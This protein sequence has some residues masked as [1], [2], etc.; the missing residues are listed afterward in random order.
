MQPEDP[1]EIRDIV[2]PD[3]RRKT[4][5]TIGSGYRYY[6]EDHPILVPVITLL[7]GGLC[8][9]S[10]IFSNLAQRVFLGSRADDPTVVSGF[11]TG[12]SWMV[13]FAFGIMALAAIFLLIQLVDIGYRRVRRKPAVCKNCGMVEVFGRAPFKHESIHG[14]TWEV[15]TCP[16]CHTEWYARR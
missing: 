5:Q 16:Q 1:P 12:T 8:L 7:L 2:P 9:Y 11:N 14:T 6:L 4:E 3:V 10:T 13:A 15:V